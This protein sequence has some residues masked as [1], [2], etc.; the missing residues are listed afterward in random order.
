VVVNDGWFD[1]F[2]TVNNK[3]NKLHYEQWSLIKWLRYRGDWKPPLFFILALELILR[4][5]DNR[6]DKGVS[7]MDS[8]LYTLG[9]ADDIDYNTW[10]PRGNVHPDAITEFEKEN[11]HYVYDWTHRCPWK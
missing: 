1:S 8:M 4:R 2:T 11:D 5:Y 3:N 9:Y 7:F 10:E 6:E